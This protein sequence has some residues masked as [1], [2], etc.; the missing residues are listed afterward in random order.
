MPENKNFSYKNEFYNSENS[1]RTYYPERDNPAPINTTNIY[2]S[3]SHNQT[4]NTKF[5][6]K[7]TELGPNQTYYYK[8]EVNETKNNIYGPPKS[9]QPIDKTASVYEHNETNDTRNIFHPPGGI[10]A[11]NLPSHQPGTKQTYMYKKETNNTTNTV[12]APPDDYAQPIPLKPSEPLTNKYYKYTSS[13]TTKNTHNR[14]DE[15][16]PLLA[17]FPTN[18]IPTNQVDGPPKNL[19]QLMATFEE[20]HYICLILFQF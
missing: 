13:T 4:E 15:R 6:L 17:P 3:Q 19:N 14:P 20:V 1:S 2:S 12:Y 5:P 10:P 18:G 7:P 16:E 11:T 8:K 9:P